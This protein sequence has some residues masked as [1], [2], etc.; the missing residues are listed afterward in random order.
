MSLPPGPGSSSGPLLQL[1]MDHHLSHGGLTCKSFMALGQHPPP[2]LPLCGS[3]GTLRRHHSTTLL[4]GNSPQTLL[5]FNPG[6]ASRP[7]P[8]SVGA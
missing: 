8:G 6:Q 4:P 3:P 2:V 5:G 1:H 7:A